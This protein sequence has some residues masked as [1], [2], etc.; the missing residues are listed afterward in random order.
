M[1]TVSQ[2]TW[3]KTMPTYRVFEAQ[4]EIRCRK[5]LHVVDAD[6]EQQAIEKVISEDWTSDPIDCGELGEP[7]YSDSG[8]VASDNPADRDHF[9]EQAVSD[10]ATRKM[11]DSPIAF[12]QRALVDILALVRQGDLAAI[13][14]HCCEALGQAWGVPAD[15]VRT[16]DLTEFGK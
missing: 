6:N 7:D 14:S 3:R 5:W 9:W 11:N 13:E 16:R 4:E 8:F 15:K 12:M 10:L 1:A 2:S